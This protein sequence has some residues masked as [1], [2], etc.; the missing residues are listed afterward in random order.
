[1]IPAFNPDE[2]E[3]ILFLISTNFAILSFQGI[4]TP[5]L[6]PFNWGII[7]VFMVG[8]AA[9]LSSEDEDLNSIEG[10]KPSNAGIEGMRVFKDV[11]RS[12]LKAAEVATALILFVLSIA[13]LFL[14]WDNLE[15]GWQLELAIFTSVSI[16]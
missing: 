12:P 7:Y 4:K 2:N 14:I 11:F 16:F 5:L 6:S 13:S 1:M 9:V 10:E 3:K 15:L 8:A